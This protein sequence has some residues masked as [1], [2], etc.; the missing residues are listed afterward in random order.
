MTKKELQKLRNK[1]LERASDINPLMMSNNFAVKYQ[2]YFDD[3][4]K[5]AKVEK[6]TAVVIFLVSPTGSG[7]YRTQW[8]NVLEVYTSEEYPEI[9]I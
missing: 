8:D 5:I 2:N 6:F 1:T 3:K 9:F 7:M 4:P